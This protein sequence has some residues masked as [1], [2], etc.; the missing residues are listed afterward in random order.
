MKLTKYLLPLIFPV[1]ITAV[2][3]MSVVN[4]SVLALVNH[5]RETQVAKTFVAVRSQQVQENKEL[6]KKIDQE[7]DKTRI[8][9]ESGEI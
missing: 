9:R 4:V 2:L 7:L 5:Q 6:I 1:L 8:M 3:V